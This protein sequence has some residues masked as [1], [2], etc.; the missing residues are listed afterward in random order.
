M[1]EF[2]VTK[3]RMLHLLAHAEASLSQGQFLA[4]RH[5]DLNPS[6]QTVLELESLINHVAS[7]GQIVIV[8]NGPCVEQSVSSHVPEAPLPEI[9]G[10][11]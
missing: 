1:R 7:D 5:Y 10:G 2:P 6:T 8:S 11:L 9:G 3:S 4:S